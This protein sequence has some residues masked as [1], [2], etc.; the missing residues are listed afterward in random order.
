[1]SATGT[2]TAQT[3]HRCPSPSAAHDAVGLWAIVRGG[4]VTTANRCATRH[5]V[6]SAASVMPTTGPAATS[7]AAGTPVSPKQATT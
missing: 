3:V 7:L 6:C 4:S 2:S 1:M 5:A